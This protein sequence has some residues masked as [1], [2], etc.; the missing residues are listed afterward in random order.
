MYERFKDVIKYT[1]KRPLLIYLLI[2]FPF[3]SSRNVVLM[4]DLQ[5]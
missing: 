3:I 5:A 1:I 4:F 2:F